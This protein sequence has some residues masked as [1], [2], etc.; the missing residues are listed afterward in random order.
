[1]A[2]MFKPCH[3][4]QPADAFTFE[5]YN[6]FL[7]DARRTFGQPGGFQRDLETLARYRARLPVCLLARCPFCAREIVEPIDIFSLN[8]FG[9]KSANQGLGWSHSMGLRAKEFHYCEH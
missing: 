9:W 1:M 8:G 5:T 2:D 6:Q 4:P 3:Q 7:T